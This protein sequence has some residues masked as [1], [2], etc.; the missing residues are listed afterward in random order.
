[1]K[2]DRER[3]G[4]LKPEQNKTWAQLFETNDVVS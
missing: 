1:M 4:K 3:K 2:Q